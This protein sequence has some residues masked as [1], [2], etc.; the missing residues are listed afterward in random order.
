MDVDFKE[1]NGSHAEHMKNYV[2]IQI[3]VQTL[4]SL[5]TGEIRPV[6]NLEEKEK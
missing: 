1:S 6:E 4:K 3:T 5:S 2:E